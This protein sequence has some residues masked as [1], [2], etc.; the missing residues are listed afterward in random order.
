MLSLRPTILHLVCHAEY[1]LRKIQLMQNTTGVSP[2]P[3]EASCLGYPSSATPTPT[4]NPHPHSH[5]TLTPTPTP[6]QVSQ[7]PPE[8]FFL[9][10]EDGD[11]ALDQLSLQRLQRGLAR[12]LLRYTKLVF[13]SACHSQPAAEVRA[14]LRLRVRV[15]VR[16]GLRSP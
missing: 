4:L 14:R 6:T 10:F 7:Y 11:G 3:P 5:P 1:D 9:G 8:A 16:C 2:H 13:A 12:G 15:R